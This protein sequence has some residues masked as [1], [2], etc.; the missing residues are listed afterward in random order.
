MSNQRFK[1]WITTQS[2]KNLLRKLSETYDRFSGITPEILKDVT[3]TLEEIQE[4]FLKI[5]D[6]D[7]ILIG[8]SLE[9]DLNAMQVIFNYLN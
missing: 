7:S 8:Q 6:K 1:S 5:V 9:N 4:E 2:I 3:T